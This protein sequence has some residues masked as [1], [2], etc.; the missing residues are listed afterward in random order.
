VQAIRKDNIKIQ[1]DHNSSM[2]MIMFPSAQILTRDIF[3]MFKN[4]TFAHYAVYCVSVFQGAEKHFLLIEE[5]CWSMRN[6]WG[7]HK[8]WASKEAHTPTM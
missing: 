6:L 7:C 4:C 8:P 3:P 5:S 2:G 1:E